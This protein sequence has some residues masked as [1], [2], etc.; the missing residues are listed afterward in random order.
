MKWGRENIIS[1][2]LDLSFL[3]QL[4]INHNSECPGSQSKNENGGTGP[5]A[6][7]EPIMK[8]CQTIRRELPDTS[9]FFPMPVF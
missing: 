4:N 2:H 8:T 1:K 3:C 7:L 6:V 5:V 9:N